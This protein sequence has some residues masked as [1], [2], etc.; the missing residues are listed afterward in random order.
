MATASPIFGLRVVRA[1][2][3]LM[4]KFR[5]PAMVTVSSRARASAIAE[6]KAPA[7]AAASAFDSDV[8]TATRAQSPVRFLADFLS[9]LDGQYSTMRAALSR[10]PWKGTAA[11]PTGDEACGGLD[12]PAT[13]T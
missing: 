4:V 12:A 7:A 1:G 3:S 8:A 9:A 11:R 10:R 6:N 5:K 13:W 2:R